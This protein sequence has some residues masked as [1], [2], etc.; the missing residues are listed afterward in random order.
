M[1][2]TVQDYGSLNRNFNILQAM[3]KSWVQRVE[4]IVGNLIP[5]H[6]HT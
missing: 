2:A 5:C 1:H 4:T 3:L 6:T